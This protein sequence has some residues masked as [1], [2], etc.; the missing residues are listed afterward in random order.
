MIYGL[1]A[2][3]YE[4]GCV[5]VDQIIGLGNYHGCGNRYVLPQLEIK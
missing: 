3:G 1:V 4:N 5:A 2:P